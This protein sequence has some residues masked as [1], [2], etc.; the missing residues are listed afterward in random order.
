MTSDV[1]ALKAALVG[2][3]NVKLPANIMFNNVY[4][5]FLCFRKTG[6]ICVDASSYTFKV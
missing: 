3:N 4:D 5:N 1:R 2:Q 6:I